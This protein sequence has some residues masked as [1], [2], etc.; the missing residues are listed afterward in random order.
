[1][2]WYIFLFLPILLYAKWSVNHVFK[3]SVKNTHSFSWI[4]DWENLSFTSK[5]IFP[6]TNTPGWLAVLD[7][8]C[9]EDFLFSHVFVDFEGKGAVI[10]EVRSSENN[11]LLTN[12]SLAESGSVFLENIFQKR[13]DVWLYLN[14]STTLYSMGIVRK[15]ETPLT[16]HDVFLQPKIVYYPERILSIDMTIKSPAW[17]ELELYNKRGDRLAS[18][19]PLSFYQAG[20]LSLQWTPLS[21][22][23]QYLMSGSA[24][25]YIRYRTST[26]GK[27]WVHRFEI[28][29]K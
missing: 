1:M 22:L 14:P 11:T 18:L 16:I 15:K 17:I 29:Y 8:S 2:R 3:V 26:S 23:K 10:V 13:I 4:S 6:I 25:V 27:E 19:I 24:Y 9:D 12:V 20:P 5:G 28:I 7:L 21:S